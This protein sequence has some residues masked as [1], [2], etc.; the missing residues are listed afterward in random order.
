MK[1]L[2]LII[3][4][5][6]CHISLASAITGF[7]QTIDDKTNMPRSIVRIYE[8][9]DGKIGGRIVAMYDTNGNI[10]DTIAAPTRRAQ[11]MKGNPYLSGLDI[12]WGLTNDGKEYNG[13]R[14][15]DP[16]SDSTYRARIWQ[17]DPTKLQV[18]GQLGIG[19]GR[20]QTWNTLSP[21]NLPAAIKNLDT[22]N[23]IP[24]PRN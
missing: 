5:I 1:K 8:Y 18:R 7:Y 12:I 3:S 19:L 22:A 9:D 14:I 2:L 16:Q 13:G 10:E 23:W 20:T 21:A 11:K 15:L 4:L 6:T 24:T 17:D